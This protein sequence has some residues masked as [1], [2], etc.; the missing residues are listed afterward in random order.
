MV[1]MVYRIEGVRQNYG[2]LTKLD[3]IKAGELLLGYYPHRK[4]L[5]TSSISVQIATSRA[6]NDRSI[7]RYQSPTWHKANKRGNR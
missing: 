3:E 6:R 4:S 5:R 1:K 7:A 2:A